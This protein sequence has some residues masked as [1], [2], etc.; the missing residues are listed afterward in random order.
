MGK[1]NWPLLHIHKRGQFRFP[2]QYISG[3][4]LRLDRIIRH[5][6]ISDKY[7][8][9]IGRL[10]KWMAEWD[11]G[12]ANK[13]YLIILNFGCPAPRIK[14]RAEQQQRLN[15]T[16]LLFFRSLFRQDLWLFSTGNNPNAWINNYQLVSYMKNR[17][18]SENLKIERKR[19]IAC[20]KPKRD[21][22]FGP[23]HETSRLM[24]NSQLP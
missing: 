22:V 12:K 2:I 16:F 19:G 11:L 9:V 13:I 23:L 20:N 14:S 4:G 1:Q 8:K 17:V 6:Q 3:H 10:Q 7:E 21:Y 15:S 18:F 5:H 24:Q